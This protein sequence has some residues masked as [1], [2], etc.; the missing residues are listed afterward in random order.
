MRLLSRKLKKSNTTRRRFLQT[1]L[2][3]LGVMSA[4]VSTKSTN[5]GEVKPAGSAQISGAKGY[6]ETDHVRRYYET[7]R[8]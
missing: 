7:V 3:S 1:L 5:A 6:Q 4:L 2:S 8:F